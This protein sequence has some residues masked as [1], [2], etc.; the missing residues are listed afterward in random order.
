MKRSLSTNSVIIILLIISIIVLFVL[1]TFNI[2][3]HTISPPSKTTY[4][5]VH[6]IILDFEFAPK[7]KHHGLIFT[8]KHGTLILYNCSKNLNSIKLG[9]PHTISYS[10]NTLIEIIP[11][12]PTL[13]P[14]TINAQNHVEA[15]K[16][17]LKTIQ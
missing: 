3:S 15:E 1:T 4:H 5:F 17:F 12:K 2:T 11:D 9:E 16:T 10:N 6:D 8:K 7:F 14:T 13:T